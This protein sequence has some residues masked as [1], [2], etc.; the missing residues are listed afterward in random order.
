[1]PFLLNFHSFFDFFKRDVPRNEIIVINYL[2]LRI[3]FNSQRSQI[4]QIYTAQTLFLHNLPSWGHHLGKDFM[5]NFLLFIF[6]F[7]HFVWSSSTCLLSDNLLKLSV[8]FGVF[9]SVN[10]ASTEWNPITMIQNSAP[11]FYR[12]QITVYHSVFGPFYTDSKLEKSIW[13]DL[14]FSMVFLDPV[15]GKNNVWR[16][17]IFLPTA[18]SQFTIDEWEVVFAWKLRIF[19]QI[20]HIRHR[21]VVLRLWEQFLFLHDGSHWIF[22]GFRKKRVVFIVSRGSNSRYWSGEVI[23]VVS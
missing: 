18:N 5:V 7:F 16:R 22:F 23:F 20:C 17:R 19:V 11:L 2:L 14:Y 10:V 13:E 15:C 21:F 8:E 1:M 3:I 4:G 6:T 12:H 9:K